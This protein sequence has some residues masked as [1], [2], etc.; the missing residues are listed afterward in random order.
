MTRQQAIHLALSILD[1]FKESGLYQDYQ[2]DE[3]FSDE[4]YQ[5]M[6]DELGAM[7]K[8]PAIEGDKNN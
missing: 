2:A 5:D 7:E 6:L 1:P 8:R 3:G 4:Q